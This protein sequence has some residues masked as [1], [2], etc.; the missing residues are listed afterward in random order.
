MTVV[1]TAKIRA[2]LV[3]TQLP[4]TGLTAFVALAVALAAGL[5]AG[6]PQAR[7]ALVGAGL[8]VLFFAL[9]AL[10]DGWGAKDAQAL[11]F[12]VVIVSFG[13]RLALLTMAV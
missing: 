8:V 13:L 1:P 12:V 11:G 10:L 4:A 2:W 5:A 9:G 3:R 6:W 7:S